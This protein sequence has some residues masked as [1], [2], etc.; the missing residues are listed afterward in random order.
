MKDLLGGV[1]L[2][3]SAT[4][5]HERTLQSDIFI[6]GMNFIFVDFINV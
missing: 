4:T 1:S 3:A 2:V 5:T 6:I